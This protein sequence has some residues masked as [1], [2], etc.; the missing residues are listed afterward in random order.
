MRRGTRE[1]TI[2]SVGIVVIVISALFPVFWL[3]MLSLKT[4][5]TVGDGRVWPKEFTLENY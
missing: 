3:L 1:Y 5:A 4:P 2:W